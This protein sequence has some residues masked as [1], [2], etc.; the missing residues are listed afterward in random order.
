[1]IFSTAQYEEFK[2]LVSKILKTLFGSYFY[3][4]YRSKFILLLKKKEWF[5]L[6]SLDKKIVP[7]LKNSRG[8]FVDVGANDG[9]TQS[10]TKHLELFKGWNGI[11][12]EPIYTQFI[13]CKKSRSGLTINSACCEFNYKKGE[14]KMIYSNLMTTNLLPT[15]EMKDPIQH[16]QSGARI[17]GLKTYEFSVVAK[18][19]NQ[20][21]DECNSPAVIDFLN[22]DVEG[23]EMSVLKGIDYGKYQFK[24]I[25]IET[26]DVTK[27]TNYLKQFGY[28]YIDKLSYHDY[29]F[30][31]TTI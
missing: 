7:Y 23:S 13:K 15:E 27:I 22:I 10:N 5:G 9:V 24:F 28:K 30:G 3:Y 8:F 25:L 11:L 20:I 14:I 19:L 29:L 26:N 12:I 6:N 18:P 16:A 2:Y 17:M 4:V 21:L 1:M 31:S